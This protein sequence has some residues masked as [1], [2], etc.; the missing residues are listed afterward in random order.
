MALATLIGLVTFTSAANIFGFA[1]G[2]MHAS[3]SRTPHFVQ[4]YPQT[5][6]H[7]TYTVTWDS[8]TVSIWNPLAISHLASVFVKRC[9]SV[10]DASF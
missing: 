7:G 3:V 6:T 1:H 8:V 10:E 2:L 5:A 9:H 4:V